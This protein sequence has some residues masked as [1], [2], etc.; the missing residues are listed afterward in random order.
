MKVLALFKK[1]KVVFL[2]FIFL[3]ILISEFLIFNRDF[4]A[5]KFFNLE[6]QRFT[7]N[8]GNLY[9]FV[10]E[11][12][13]LVAQGND[14]NIT[15]NDINLRVGLISIDCVGSS[16]VA[17]GQV[18]YR[19]VDESFKEA[20]SVWY[21]ASSIDKPLL[22]GQFMGFPKIIQI[23]SLRFDLTNIPDDVVRCSEF[24]INPHSPLKLDR[25]RLVGYVIFLILSSV[26]IFRNDKSYWYPR[27][28]FMLFLLVLSFVLS[29]R[30]ATKTGNYLISFSIIAMLFEFMSVNKQLLISV[31][32]EFL[33]FI[34]N[35]RWFWIAIMITVLLAYGFT[36][37][38]YSVSVDDESM[39]KYCHRGLL[40]QGR[41]GIMFFQS[42]FDNCEFI[43]FWVDAIGLIVLITAIVFWSMFY[44]RMSHGKLEKKFTIIFACLCISFPVIAYLFIFMGGAYSIGLVLLFT[45]FALILVASWLYDG[46]NASGL[47]SV[48]T[49][50]KLIAA[51]FFLAISIG[52]L[53]WTTSLFL[54]GIFSGLLL[55][56]V[57]AD[58]EKRISLKTFLLTVLKVVVVLASAIVLNGMLTFLYQKVNGIV[59]SGYTSNYISWK[60]GTV[61][62]EFSRFVAALSAKFFRDFYQGK[63][64]DLWLV[65]FNYAITIYISI[66][67]YLS[68]KTKNI[69]SLIIV[70]CII[71]SAFSLNIVTGNASLDP[72]IYVHLAIPTAFSFMLLA[73]MFWGEYRVL[74]KL[75]QG[76]FWFLHSG[77]KVVV[78]ISVILIVLYQTKELSRLFYF[79]YLRYEADVRTAYKIIDEIEEQEGSLNK[80][81]IFIGSFSSS[82]NVKFGYII[83]EHD[84]WN[85]PDTMKS[86]GRIIGFIRQLGY[87]MS[88][89]QSQSDI[90]R[91]LTEA[92]KMP[93]YPKKGSIKVF[94]NF[95][96]IKFGEPV[97]GP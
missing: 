54:T 3:T 77:A 35:N 51:I 74:E 13:R 61:L 59:P 69:V 18:F 66:A 63:G 93:S 88:P 87:D 2:G 6:E 29:V 31:K 43:P 42:I 94:D 90:D 9:Q 38:N 39:Y 81:V 10:Y 15:F 49:I 36:L 14:P 78:I 22:L 12:G 55:E 71:G 44:I 75:D 5:Y 83:Y 28:A 91:A 32:N 52:L 20:N 72:R 19:D 96:A 95:V 25:V 50:Y 8:D 46:I 84:R 27:I 97:S 92:Q 70:I 82:A 23:S 24:V 73:Y 47:H 68:F 30:H 67:T 34:N 45:A 11:N 79:E 62:Y 1:R 4:L 17:M 33:D 16:P 21:A 80:P 57:C 53:E 41:F 89:V 40:A 86:Q 56:Y 58:T 7:I 48:T 64:V 76:D 37:T 65:I 26:V 85:L 60:G